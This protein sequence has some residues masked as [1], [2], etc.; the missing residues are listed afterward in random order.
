MNGIHDLGGVHGFGAIEHEPDE[1]V[2]HH[3][4]EGRAWGL[5]QVL[6]LTRIRKG[7]DESRYD[8]E[9]LDPAV[10]LSSSYYERWLLGVERSLVR[11]GVVTAVELERGR[12]ELGSDPERPLPSRRDDDLVAR[13]LQRAAHGRPSSME[14]ESA[15]RFAVGEAVVTRNV[16]TRRHTRLPRYARGRRG[17]VER[18]YDAFALPEL[19]AEDVRDPQYV[20]AVRFSAAELWG[21]SAEPNATVCIDLFESYLRSP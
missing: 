13:A 9:T 17:T 19:A 11:R 18:V 5:A 6:S 4:W 21:E 8:M 15:P 7:L 14:V 10:Y 3:P 20:Y 16:H 12:E 2:F 1:P